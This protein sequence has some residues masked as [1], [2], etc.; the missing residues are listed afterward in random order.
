M[1]ALLAATLIWS[2]SFG[3]IKQVLAGVPGEWIA[4]LRLALAASFFLLIAAR[5]G[6]GGPRL[7]LGAIGGVQFG[8]MYVLYLKSYEWLMAWEVALFTAFTPIWVLLF[9]ARW[10]KGSAP[11]VAHIAWLAVAICVL[12]AWLI[13]ADEVDLPR[14]G[15]GFFWVQAANLCFAFGQVAYRRILVDRPDVQDASAHAWMFLGGTLVAGIFAGWRFLVGFLN[16]P[17][18]AIE[19]FAIDLQ[20]MAALVYLGLVAAGFGFLLWNA[21][22]RQVSAGV[23]ATMNNLK[24]PGAVLISLLFFGESLSVSG[25]SGEVARKWIGMA[26]VLAAVLVAGFAARSRR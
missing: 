6:Q 17:I 1:L 11:Q 14:F 4:F 3:I 15:E 16:S 26:L 10:R 21:G 22:A 8:L 18:H 12:G 2:F 24:V 7:R 5:L 13:R 20:Q 9:E 25:S 19:S 23:L